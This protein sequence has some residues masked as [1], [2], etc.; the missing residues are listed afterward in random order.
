MRAR[1]THI[2]QI[3]DSRCGLHYHAFYGTS[4]CRGNMGTLSTAIAPIIVVGVGVAAAIVLAMA[5]PVSMRRPP[6]YSTAAAPTVA[7][8]AQKALVHNRVVTATVHAA[9]ADDATSAAILRSLEAELRALRPI[10]TAPTVNFTP[11]SANTLLRRL[12]STQDFIQQTPKGRGVLL[13]MRRGA[14]ILAPA[15]ALVAYA[16]PFRSYGQVIILKIEHTADKKYL[17][18]SG[19]HTLRVAQG[20]QVLAGQTIAVFDPTANANLYAEWRAGA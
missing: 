18:L 12:S 9:L 15:N 5:S 4:L 20:K 8:P 16:G 7:A 11:P 2:N 19:N 3:I 17:V 13:Q 6:V 14:K 10:V 1:G